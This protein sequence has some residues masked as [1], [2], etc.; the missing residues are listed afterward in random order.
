MPEL[1]RPLGCTHSRCAAQQSQ[2]ST[3]TSGFLA[4]MRQVSRLDFSGPVGTASAR[5]K[6]RCSI[7]GMFTG[8]MPA[9]PIT[10]PNTTTFEFGRRVASARNFSKTI[11]C[12]QKTYQQVPVGSGNRTSSRSRYHPPKSFVDKAGTIVGEFRRGKHEEASADST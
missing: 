11:S 2:L 6:C 3:D 9:E 1:K 8:R 4:S 5:H 10:C 7:V 12:S